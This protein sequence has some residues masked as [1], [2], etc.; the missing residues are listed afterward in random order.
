MKFSKNDARLLEFCIQELEVRTSAEVVLV[1]RE[2]SGNYR[3]IAYLI[4]A[5]FSWVLLLSAIAAPFEIPEYWL[6]LPMV[7]IFVL[8][9]WLVNRT[10]SRVWFTSARR[11][12]LQVAKAAHACFYE[13]KIHL[14]EAHSGILV[15]CSFL[16]RQVEI[17][18]DRAAAKALSETVVQEFRQWIIERL[19]AGSSHSEQVRGLL[20]VL[21]SFGVHLGKVLPPTGQP[22]LN[23]LE[24]APE[25]GKREDI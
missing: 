10:A 21:R 18:M 13:N 14:T 9:A 25:L 8:V 12:H 3:D 6:P 1:I 4:G 22:K 7:L 11:L 24:N 23:E 5:I 15:Y 20:E 17:V 19:Y 2:S 16:E